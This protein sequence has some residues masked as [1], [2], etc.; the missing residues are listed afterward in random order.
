MTQAETS[1]GPSDARPDGNEGREAVPTITERIQS[2]A[3]LVFGGAVA[4]FFVVVGLILYFKP[5]SDAPSEGQAALDIF[6]AGPPDTF[7]TGTVTYFEEEHLLL[8]RHRDGAFLALYD[9]GPGAQA[10]VASDQS[11]LACRVVIRQD[12]K[13]ASWLE[14]EAPID[15]FSDTGFYDPCDD[16]AWD[17]YG[18]RVWGE[19]S[20]DLDRFPVQTIA[21]IVRIHLGDRRCMNETKAEA[22]CIPTQ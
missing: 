19:P 4:V 20:G 12:E 5:Y 14:S 18:R 2:R 11:A 6:A 7:A 16:V 9:L 1:K 10:R 13:M 21:D 15:G 22:S 8:V 3:M 17:A